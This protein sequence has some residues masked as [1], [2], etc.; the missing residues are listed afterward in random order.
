MRDQN[1]N[2]KGKLI[3]ILAILAVAVV[4]TVGLTRGCSYASEPTPAENNGQPT[5]DAP[6]A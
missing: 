2:S 3:P 6:D 1:H 5:R 4:G